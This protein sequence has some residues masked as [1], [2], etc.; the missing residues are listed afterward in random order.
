MGLQSCIERQAAGLEQFAEALH[1]VAYQIFIK[2][3]APLQ[4]W[5]SAPSIEDG[6]IDGVVLKGAYFL[7][8]RVD[9]VTPALGKEE[10]PMGIAPVF[11]RDSFRQLLGP[12]GEF[13]RFAPA[14]DQRIEVVTGTAL[15]IDEMG[16]GLF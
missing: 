1:R 7:H 9:V 8:R 12:G 16:I 14:F 5:N 11:H 2:H 4:S 13:F 3:F 15:Y 6:L 10:T